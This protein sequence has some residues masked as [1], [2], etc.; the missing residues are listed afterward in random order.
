MQ[1]PFNNIYVNILRVKKSTF[2]VHVR[3]ITVAVTI[4]FSE[5]LDKDLTFTYT[6]SLVVLKYTV[7][8]EFLTCESG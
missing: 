7:F 1:H 8:N 5:L 3:V 4:F 6:I 2:T